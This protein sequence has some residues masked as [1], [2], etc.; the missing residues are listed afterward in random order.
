ML[1]YLRKRTWSLDNTLIST[2][3]KVNLFQW[4]DWHFNNFFITAFISFLTVNYVIGIDDV[5]ALNSK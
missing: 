2:L 5:F 1:H 4:F 3:S